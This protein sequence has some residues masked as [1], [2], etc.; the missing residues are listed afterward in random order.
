MLDL[1]KSL[2]IH[3]YN[4]E[5]IDIR[6][7]ED[8]NCSVAFYQKELFNVNEEVK[9]GAFIRVFS[10]GKWYYSSTTK[11]NEIE[12]ELQNL[13]KTAGISTKKDSLKNIKYSTNIHKTIDDS[14]IYLK[15]IKEKKE[16]LD[17]IRPHIENDP[18]I[19]Q[20][21]LIWN[22][23]AKKKWYI[24]NEGVCNYHDLAFSGILA[25]YTIVDNG[26]I[27]N[28]SFHRTYQ[29]GDDYL[30]YKN[31]LKD[32][33]SE[34]KL[35]VNVETI[36]PGKYPVVLSPEAT[37]I[38]AHESFGHKS[39]ADFMIGD[40]SMEEEW[41]IGKKVANDIVSIIDD[42]ND[43][44]NTGFCPV[45]DEGN[46]KEK[47]YLIKNGI[48]SGRLH[49]QE[50]AT[51]LNESPTGN[52]RAINFLYEPIVR[53]TCT[54]IEKGDLSFDELIK[55]I[56]KGFFIKKLAHGSGMSTFTLAVNRAFEIENGKITGPVKINMATGT[57]FDT[58]YNIEALSNEVVI[59]SSIFGGCG[60]NEQWP[61]S[62]SYGG[63]YVR[64]S[65]LNLS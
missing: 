1:L 25:N 63:P 33:V 59:E 48:L 23:L 39:E 28:T 65:E 11:L 55:P 17:E 19:V 45:D 40:K 26:N 51:I 37:G 60:K 49:S 31:R 53:M 50:T 54:Y 20:P 58:L 61:L 13:L 44:T 22:D 32:D 10:E 41:S 24:N 18:L 29:K 3:R 62:V 30:E 8:Y 42:G 7:E 43:G 35:F 64:L 21:Y 36:K 34:A 4:C 5:I 27:F 56:K 52:A 14:F 2:E 16:F 6:L 12:K 9:T 47:V 38:F 46:K 15:S 57:V